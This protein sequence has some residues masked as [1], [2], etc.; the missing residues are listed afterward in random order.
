MKNSQKSKV[1]SQKS[2]DESRKTK[3]ESRKLGLILALCTISILPL[4]AQLLTLDSCLS[5]ARQRNCTIRSAALEVAIS[6][7]VKK[8]MLWKYFP[9]VSLQGFAFGAAKPLI[10]ADVTEMGL[11]GGTKDLLKSTFEILDQIAKSSDPNAEISSNVQ[12]L[13]WGGLAKAQAMQ[14]V[15]W[16]G[17]I[18]T[19]N[20]LAKLGID[21]SRLKQEVSE[22]DVL[23]EVTDTYWLVAGL[24]EKR[25]T[26]SKVLSLLDTV[27]TIANVA[28]NNGLVTGND[29]LKVQLKMNEMQTKSMQLED[30]IQLASRLLCQ[31]IGQP[32]DHE[33]QLEP[34]PEP[35][36][37]SLAEQPD[38]I[39]ISQRPEVQLLELNVRY[40]K[41]NKR[42]TLGEALPHLAVGV[43]GGYSNFFEKHTWNGLALVNLSI[44]L[45]GWG[46]MAHRLKQHNMQIEQ[47]ELMQQDLSGKLQ[48][49]NRQVY[50]QLIESLKL[51]EQ[52]R[53]A[54]QLAQDNYR[55]SLMNYEA[56]VGTMSELMESEALLLQAENAFTDAL[57]TY[58]TAQRKYNDYNKH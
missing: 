35:Q 10:D 57:I 38:T 34:L 54:R 20:K 33:L 25:Q 47:A 40:N 13:R 55:I 56:G 1:D 21:A 16:G 53:S 51:M 26:V 3:V 27:N 19:A 50:D 2:K 8:Q 32:Y 39:C 7:E 42:L 15:Y 29:L 4:R 24:M 48:L 18:V 30:G 17:Q 58:C 36:L 12:M 11:K 14:P 22:R 5:S 46:E 49:Q 45:T 31:L 9:Q 52:H 44:P 37:S 41:L 23:Q 43:M 6:Q 28:Y